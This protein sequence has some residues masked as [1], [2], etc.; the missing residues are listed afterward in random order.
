MLK[1]P[2]S[3]D[4]KVSG[5]PSHCKNAGKRI[6]LTWCFVLSS[7]FLAAPGSLWKL[8]G[9]NWEYCFLFSQFREILVLSFLHLFEERG[10]AEKPHTSVGWLDSNTSHCWPFIGV[11]QSLQDC[12]GSPSNT[13]ICNLLIH[14]PGSWKCFSFMRNLSQYHYV[15]CIGLGLCQCYPLY[16]NSRDKALLLLDTKLI[17][18]VNLLY[19]YVK[20]FT[21][22]VITV[23]KN[24]VSKDL[25]LHPKQLQM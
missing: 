10:R 12:F 22:S 11:Q 25:P 4:V 1:I 16:F 3:N 20:C 6:K 24:I 9:W 23:S 7:S 8:I 2:F 21:T 17:P 14:M 15:S 5:G 19:V 18:Q 13:W